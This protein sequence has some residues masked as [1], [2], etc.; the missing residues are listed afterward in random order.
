MCRHAGGPGA[1]HRRKWGFAPDLLRA[2]A[3][4]ESWWRMSTVGD[5]GDSFG[6][7]QV[8]RPYHCVEP[9][10]EQF[11]GDAAFNADYYGGI[12]RSYYD[13]RQTWLHTV[14][15]E[16]GR[17]YRKRDLWGSVGAWFSGRWWNEPA[18]GYVREVKRRLAERTWRSR[19]F[20]DG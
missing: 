10:C 6:L 7:F 14:A 2:V 13:G 18:R 5:G 8:R 3:T 12:L 4:A 9:V 1:P 15:D 11:R 17:R 20:R 16:N 19:D